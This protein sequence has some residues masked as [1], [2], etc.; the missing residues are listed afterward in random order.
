M[1]EYLLQYQKKRFETSII[2][3][4]ADISLLER[5]METCPLY[6]PRPDAAGHHGYDVRVITKLLN[7]YRSHEAILR[8][9]NKMFYDS[10]LKSCASIDRQKFCKQAC[11]VYVQLL[12]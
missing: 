7:N 8:L 5:Y 12:A 10:E 6:A 11:A 1:L 3:C 9:P 4:V 2:M